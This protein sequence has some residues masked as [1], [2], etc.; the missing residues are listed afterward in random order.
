MCVSV[1]AVWRAIE[2]SRSVSI[3]WGAELSAE[4]NYVAIEPHIG[5]SRLQTSRCSHPASITLPPDTPESPPAKPTLGDSPP[6]WGEWH[7]NHSASSQCHLFS[8]SFFIHDPSCSLPYLDVGTLVSCVGFCTGPM[9]CFPWIRDWSFLWK[10]WPFV[11]R[12][13]FSMPIAFCCKN[14]KD[15][16]A[17]QF[18]KCWGFLV[19]VE[20]PF[21]TK[22]WRPLLNKR[23]V[24]A[25]IWC[26]GPWVLSSWLPPHLHVYQLWVQVIVF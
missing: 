3:L 19:A 2:V 12:I 26:W 9:T 24:L 22:D 18:W 17:S 11:P 6:V 16:S 1:C 10:P 7:Y 20:S 14:N 15:L 5:S 4:V 23:F 21:S 8:M 25:G 13:S